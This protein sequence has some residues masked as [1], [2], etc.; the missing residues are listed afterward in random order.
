MQI[1]PVIL[2]INIIKLHKPLMSNNFDMM[3]VFTVVFIFQ[4]SYPVQVEHKLS[5]SDMLKFKSVKDLVDY[6]I[7]LKS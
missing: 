1:V 3:L 5:I 6:H 2:K 4:V 7:Y